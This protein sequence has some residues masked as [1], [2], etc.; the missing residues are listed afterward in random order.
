MENT[1][2]GPAGKKTFS[3]EGNDEQSVK[4]GLD[5]WNDRLDNNLEPEDHNDVSA[6]ERAKEYT[7]KFRD[8]KKSDPLD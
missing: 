1:P 6:D 2:K 8:Q 7:D 4:K 3:P 5:N